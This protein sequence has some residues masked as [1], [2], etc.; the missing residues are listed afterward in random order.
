[1]SR[2]YRDLAGKFFSF[3]F[4]LLSCSLIHAQQQ[5]PDRAAA[6]LR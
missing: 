6:D 2:P 4:V 5:D 1:M 3:L